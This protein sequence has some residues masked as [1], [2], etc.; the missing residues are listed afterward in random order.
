MSNRHKQ[1]FNSLN[2]LNTT[3]TNRLQQKSQYSTASNNRS[4]Y[5]TQFHTNNSAITSTRKALNKMQ[6]SNIENLTH[7]ELD[8]ETRLELKLSDLLGL[9]TQL[10]QLPK[11]ANK[12]H[13][14]HPI[15]TVKE[16]QIS[17]NSVVT[18]DSENQHSNTRYNHKPILTSKFRTKTGGRGDLGL[19][20]SNR[21]RKRRGIAA[22]IA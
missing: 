22:L 3:V 18:L 20:C 14:A 9:Q 16:Q 5:S 19:V 13:K 7:Q 4:I 2:S 6:K 12:H 15:L 10:T 1:Q 17:S 11:T 21:K 8:K